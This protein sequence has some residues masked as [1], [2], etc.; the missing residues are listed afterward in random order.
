[1]YGIVEGQGLKQITTTPF[2]TYDTTGQFQWLSQV[3][4]LAPCQPSKILAMALN[5]GSHLGKADAPKHPEPFLKAPN[6]LIGYRDTIVLPGNAGRVDEE[7]ELVVVI[8]RRCTKVSEGDALSFVL[9]Y[10]CG[11]DVSARVWQR[12]D[13]QWWRAKSSDTFTAIGPYIATGLDS[14]NLDIKARI[15]GVEVQ[16]CNSRDLI[17]GIPTIISFISQVMTLEAGDIIFTG[18]SGKPAELHDEDTVEIEVEGI[19]TLR[20]YVKAAL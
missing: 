2:E 10:T 17:F 18:T 6:S 16:R 5:Y 4:L 9:G 8:G 11:N 3:R 19:G 13:I 15:N 1:M 14:S 7:G 20:N 12:N